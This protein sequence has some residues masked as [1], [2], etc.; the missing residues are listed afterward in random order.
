MRSEVEEVEFDAIRKVMDI[1]FWGT[2]YCTKAGIA[3]YYEEQRN[4]CGRFIYCR[5]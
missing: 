1:N 2:V 4:H 3:I 5:I